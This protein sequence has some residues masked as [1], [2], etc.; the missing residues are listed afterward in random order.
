[1]SSMQSSIL[2]HA[3]SFPHLTECIFQNIVKLL[4]KSKFNGD[5]EILVVDHL[6]NFIKKCISRKITNKL[7]VCRTFTLNFKFQIRKWFDPFTT[8]SIHLWEHFM[9]LFLLAHQNYDY[10]EL[11]DYIEYLH[12]DEDESIANFNL[13]IIQNYYIFYD[14]DR[15]SK[16]YLIH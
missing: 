12:R 13:R 14:D 6:H 1:M 5:S 9:E 4:S 2:D 15:P 16:E 11:C 10:D 8:E 3:F 7:I